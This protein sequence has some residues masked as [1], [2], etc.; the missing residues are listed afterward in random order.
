[1]A[2]FGKKKEEKTEKKE[3]KKTP[4]KTEKKSAAKPAKKTKAKV[5]TKAPAKKSNT[6]TKKDE[7][8]V[9]KASETKAIYHIMFNA[10]TKVWSIKKDKAKRI[11]ASYKT[12]D[13]AVARAKKLADSND[14]TIM[15]YKKDGKVQVLTNL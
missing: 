15:I 6:S 10:E 8:V 11:I 2:L 4:A 5:S 14:V 3:V 12:K 7:V 9:A 1:M 13:E